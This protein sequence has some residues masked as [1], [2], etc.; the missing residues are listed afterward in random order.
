MF[1]LH[2]QFAN[3]KKE[4]GLTISTYTDELKKKIG[5]LY[6]NKKP[7]NEIVKEYKISRSL[8]KYWLSV[9]TGLKNRGVQD[10]MIVLVDG[11]QGFVEALGAA[12]FTKSVPLPAMFPTKTQK[13]HCQFKVDI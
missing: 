4:R 13:I 1:N 7:A 11:L 8:S 10:I 6:N 3:I 9:L 12:S 5:S 2:L